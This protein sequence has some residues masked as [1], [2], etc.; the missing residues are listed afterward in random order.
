MVCLLVDKLYR[1][2]S[3]NQS[4][5][6]NLLVVACSSRDKVLRCI[7][8][9]LCLTEDRNHYGVNV[10]L[11]RIL[12]LLFC[13]VNSIRLFSMKQDNSSD[14]TDILAFLRSKLTL[15]V[16]TVR[17][18]LLVPLRKVTVSGDPINKNDNTEENVLRTRPQER[19]TLRLGL[20]Q[21]V[22]HT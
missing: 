3:T 12:I 11:M 20:K 6:Y 5:C 14:I 1:K 18:L 17:I 21:N 2:K 13:A 7:T 19:C 10:A 9:A 15:L 22:T 16:G 4:K 8:F